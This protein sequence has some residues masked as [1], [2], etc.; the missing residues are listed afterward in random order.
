MW[1][2]KLD[3]M[4][5]IA[6]TVQKKVKNKAKPNKELMKKYLSIGPH[7]RNQVLNT[8]MYERKQTY[9]RKLKEYVAASKQ[10]L[11][12]KSRTKAIRA[13]LNSGKSPLKAMVPP[14]KPIF[15]FMPT[16]LEMARLIEGI[17]NSS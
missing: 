9:K 8:Y 17:V 2:I 6:A 4:V 7:A 16:E 3:E 14:K 12:H 11:D 13:L 5:K 10:Y 1:N 15:E